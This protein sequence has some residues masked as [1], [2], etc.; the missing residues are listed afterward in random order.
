MSQLSENQDEVIDNMELMLLCMDLKS[1][2]AHIKRENQ[3]V[4]TRVGEL[5]DQLFGEKAVDCSSEIHTQ[6]PS[7][8]KL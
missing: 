5:E 4:C 6:A 3:P 2:V 1:E 8:V 7:S